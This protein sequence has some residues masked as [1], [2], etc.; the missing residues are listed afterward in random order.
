MSGRLDAPGLEMVGIKNSRHLFDA[1]QTKVEREE[2]AQQAEIPIATLDELF[3]LSDLSR[4]Y[5]VGPVFA[6]MIFDLGIRSIGAFLQYSAE[7][8]VKIYETQTQKKADFG[9]NEIEFSLILAKDLDILG[10]DHHNE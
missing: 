3:G 7:E 5:D 9:I 6:R 1:A 8:F 4:V 10:D 2:L